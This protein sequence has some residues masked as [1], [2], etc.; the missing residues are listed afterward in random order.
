MTSELII[1][2]PVAPKDEIAATMALK[3]KDGK[4][5]PKLF[6]ARRLTR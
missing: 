3:E 5:Y 1:R 2:E 6:L 4:L